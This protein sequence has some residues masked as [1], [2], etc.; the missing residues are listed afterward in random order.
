MREYL[1]Q[2]MQDRGWITA[3]EA[4]QRAG[5]P[6]STMYRWMD[7]KKVQTTRVGSARY[8][9]ASSLPAILDPID[10]QSTK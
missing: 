3:A 6:L 7:R 1:T 4:A 2:K 8:V 10:P 5:V 9:L